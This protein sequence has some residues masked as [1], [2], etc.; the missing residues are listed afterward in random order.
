M[1]EN[2]NIQKS[3]FDS[4]KLVTNG[5][6]FNEFLWICAGVNRKVLRQCPTD[7]AKYAG[8]GG[9]ILF[10]ALMAM[11][12]G[13]YALFTVFDRPGLAIGFGVFWG[14]LIFNLDRFMVNTMYSDGTSKITK[15]EILSGLPRLILAIF[16]GVVISTPMELKIF[17]DRINAQI[18]IDKGTVGNEI[19]SVHKDLDLQIRQLNQKKQ[20][21]IHR[22]DSKRVELSKAEDELNDET[23]GTGRTGKFGYGPIA[24]QL[25]DKVDRLKSEVNTI[26]DE[27]SKENKFIDEQLAVLY[28][29]K[30]RYSEQRNVATESMTGFTARL[31]ALHKITSSDGTLNVARW[32]VMLLFIAIEIIPTLFKMMQESGPYDDLL[33]AEKHRVKVLAD[34]RISDINDIINTEVKISVKKN[35]ERLNHEISANKVILENLAKSQTILLQTAIDAWR[36]NELKKINEDPSLYIRVVDKNI[37]N[38]PNIETSDGD[39]ETK[40]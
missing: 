26:S 28:E 31:Q 17:E 18:E 13:G 16:L 30:N 35:E 32:V 20:E 9:T 22:V 4:E 29:Q 14:L 7:Y 24:K 8:I 27:V 33:R 11:I 5:G 23:G 39:D 2:K 3:I 38:P 19:D 1:E 10:T 15:E 37:Q 34:K 21:N 12:S 6:F 40:A 25:Q 36:E